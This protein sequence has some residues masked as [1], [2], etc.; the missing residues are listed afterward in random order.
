[1]TVNRKAYMV[2]GGIGS[3]AAAAF[4]IRDAGMDGKNITIYEALNVAGGSMDGAGEPEKGY[5]IRGGRMLTTDNY[6]CVWGLFK[7]IPSI[8]NPGKT[9]TKKPLSSTIESKRT[10]A[11][12]S[13]T[14]IVQFEM[15]SRWHLR[16]ETGSNCLG[17]PKLARSDWGKIVLQIGCRR[18]FSK[19]ISGTCGLRHS[20]SSPG[21]ALLSSNV[22]CIDS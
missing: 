7:T 13:L 16:C 3:L 18:D 14:A 4:L 9:V 21:T 6:E 11:R 15:S 12:V 20:P 5:V 17:S 2:G 1:M 19:L 10:Q 8:S 22:I